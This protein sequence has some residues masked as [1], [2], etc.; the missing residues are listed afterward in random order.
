M[1]HRQPTSAQDPAALATDPA[2]RAAMRSSRPAGHGA[3]PAYDPR[4][5]SRPLASAVPH[6]G[7]ELLLQPGAACRGHGG[8]HAHLARF[9]PPQDM[10]II[11]ALPRNATGK[12]LKRELRRQ[13]VG[14]QTPAIS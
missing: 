6:R 3:V 10:A 14:S 2:A 1:R 5:R 13:F 9:K 8:D 7:A 4:T 11:D 12:V